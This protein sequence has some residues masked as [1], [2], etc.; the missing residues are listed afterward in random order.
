LRASCCRWLFPADVEDAAQETFVVDRS[1][2]GRGDALHA[3]VSYSNNLFAGAIPMWIVNL[4]AAALRGSGNV[5]IPALVTLIGAI[6]TI[7]ISP[8]LIFGFGP[9]P[10]LGIGGAGLAFGSITARRCCSC[11]PSIWRPE[12]R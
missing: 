11:W 6:V 5:K 7:P 9:S 4:Q 8:L 12:P 2:G 3:A 1:L 10:R